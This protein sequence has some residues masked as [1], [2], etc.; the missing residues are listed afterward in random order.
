MRATYFTA[1]VIGLTMIAGSASAAP[2][3]DSRGMSCDAA[4][5]RLQSVGAA[6]V[7]YGPGLYRRAVA[8]RG[9]CD[10]W[11]L[12]RPFH[13]P[14]ADADQCF[15]GYYCKNRGPTPGR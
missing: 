13:V 9:F 1:A 6:T 7:V 2:R 8:H 5:S 11:Q 12:L 15:I 14:T 4:F 10:R 3:F